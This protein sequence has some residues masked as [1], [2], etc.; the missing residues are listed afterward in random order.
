M[1]ALDI[2]ST[3]MA[4]VYCVEN[5]DIVAGSIAY[6]RDLKFAMVELV[7]T[8]DAT[9][10]VYITLSKYG[11]KRLLGIYSWVHTANNSIVTIEEDTCTVDEGVVTVTIPAGTN[12]D[13]RVI[14]LIGV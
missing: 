14:T 12:D 2:D 10:Y 13:K 1:T 9:D 8:T 3:N 11:M 7:D 5:R 4:H 6:P